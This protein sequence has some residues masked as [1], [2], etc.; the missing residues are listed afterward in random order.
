MSNTDWPLFFGSILIGFGPIASL[1]FFVVAKRAQL[2]IFAITSAFIWLVAILITATFWK[3]LPFLNDSVVGTVIFTIILEEIVR[4]GLYWMYKLA[5]KKISKITNDKDHL[6]LNDTTSSIA[7]GVGFSLMRALM[8]YGPVVASS[9]GSR[10]AAF[11]D[12]CTYL[13]LL[14]SSGLMTLAGTVMDVGLMVLGFEGY[15]NKNFVYIGIVWIIHFGSGLLTLAN[16]SEN[17]C[18]YSI[19]LNF[20]AALLAV[21]GAV[22]A[23]R[24]SSSSYHNL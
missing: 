1:Y 2:A 5:E 21:V 7:G 20:G 6:P 14:F 16:Q 10:G 19:P 22:L 11:S 23:L 8:M 12:S 24:A 3:I 18:V 9:V 13:P 15:K 4:F 17:G